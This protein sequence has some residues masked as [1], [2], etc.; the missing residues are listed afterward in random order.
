MN[1]HEG[2]IAINRHKTGEIA[3]AL[4]RIADGHI[5]GI[6]GDLLSEKAK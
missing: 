5:Q 6:D 3:D 4:H 2:Q 1:V